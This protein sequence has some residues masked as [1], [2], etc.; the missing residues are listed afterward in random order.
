M[1]ALIASCERK[2]PGLDISHYCELKDFACGL[3]NLAPH[4]PHELQSGVSFFPPGSK[5]GRF[6]KLGLCRIRPKFFLEINKTFAFNDHVKTPEDLFVLRDDDRV[7]LHAGGVK[8]CYL[9]NDI[10]VAK[11]LIYACFS[12][13]F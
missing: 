12:T 13:D 1:N 6:F 4:E 2:G 3:S 5:R 11:A 8:A 10:E 7:S 9:G